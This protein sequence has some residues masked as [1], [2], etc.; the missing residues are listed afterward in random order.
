MATEETGAPM[1]T[2]PFTCALGLLLR[3]GKNSKWENLE[4]VLYNVAL[5]W[6]NYLSQT[7]ATLITYCIL[8][9]FI[10]SVVIQITFCKKEKSF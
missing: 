6:G 1:K 10:L 2:T 9:C 4:F 7:Q 3:I 5:N 8:W